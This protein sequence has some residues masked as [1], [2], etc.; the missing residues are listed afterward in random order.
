MLVSQL[1]ELLGAMLRCSKGWLTGHAPDMVSGLQP[2]LSDLGAIQGPAALR[3]TLRG[4]LD[5][6]YLGL[7]VKESRQ[8]LG[9]LHRHYLSNVP[10]GRRVVS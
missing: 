3:A 6:L 8:A 1:Q 2:M 5:K 10:E 4:V 7:R 9:V